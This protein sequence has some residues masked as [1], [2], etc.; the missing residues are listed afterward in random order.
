[1][2]NIFADTL[3]HITRLDDLKAYCTN[4]FISYKNLCYKIKNLILEIEPEF[5]LDLVNISYI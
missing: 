4:K 3:S 1:M 2:D 5:I